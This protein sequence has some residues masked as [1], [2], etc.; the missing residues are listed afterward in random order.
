MRLV[1]KPQ[2]FCRAGWVGPGCAEEVRRMV[3]NRMFSARNR[4]VSDHSWGCFGAEAPGRRARASLPGRPDLRLVAATRGGW[5]LRGRPP[6][7]GVGA[8]LPAVLDDR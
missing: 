6:L 2:R 4:A 5:R 8:P 7:L 1:T 3:R